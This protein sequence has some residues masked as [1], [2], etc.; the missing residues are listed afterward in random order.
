MGKPSSYP[1][2]HSQYKNW[3][4]KFTSYAGASYPGLVHLLEKAEKSA[5]GVDVENMHLNTE[6]THL[7]HQLYYMLVMTCTE[8]ALNI[9][10]NSPSEGLLAWRALKL[11][12]HPISAASVTSRLMQLMKFKFEG[13]VLGRLQQFDRLVTEY[14]TLKGAP[15]EEDIKIGM[16]LQNLEEGRLKEHLTLQVDRV[17]SYPVLV[18]EIKSFFTA[19]RVFGAP[20]GGTA[21]LAVFGD[22]REKLQT[23]EDELAAFRKG[24]KGDG[25]S[26]KGGGKS[27]PKAG[28]A[29]GQPGAKPPP[30]KL[31]PICQKGYHWAAECYHRNGAKGGGKTP[32]K[33]KAS[34]QPKGGGTTQRQR[35]QDDSKIRCFKC[36]QLGHRSRDCPS[37]GNTHHELVPQPPP[38]TTAQ[39]VV[40][41]SSSNRWM[42]ATTIGLRLQSVPRSERRSTR[43]RP[44][45]L[46]QN[47]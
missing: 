13:D 8:K 27:S 4:I 35:P 37:K 25:K 12:A 42:A 14:E 34:G 46:S 36:K 22:L 29:K 17:R 16:V 32:S 38:P 44:R 40:A 30:S 9:V 3:A 11:D 33:Q 31:C 2:E 5:D 7:S 10:A 18:G 39:A 45:R 23:L 26:Y 28:T 21:Q 47:D 6:E 20:A 19:L 15:L 1:G 41:D 24:G 43:V